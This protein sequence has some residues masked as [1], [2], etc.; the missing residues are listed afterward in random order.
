MSS[1]TGTSSSSLGFI[2]VRGFWLQSD[3]EKGTVDVA[4][5]DDPLRDRRPA[6]ELGGPGERE[7]RRGRGVGR[8]GGASIHRPPGGQKPAR[9]P[10]GDAPGG[11]ERGRD[12][13]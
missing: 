10:P 4:D 9:P 12:R 11:G 7:Q 1:A 6:P 13:P 8:G 3:G 2:T 5:V